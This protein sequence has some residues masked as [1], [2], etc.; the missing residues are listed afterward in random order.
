MQIE[1]DAT[2]TSLYAVDVSVP[3]A[4]IPYYPASSTHSRFPIHA[5]PIPEYVLHHLEGMRTAFVAGS[6]VIVRT[7]TAPEHALIEYWKKH[8]T[9]CPEF[10]VV[11]EGCP[12]PSDGLKHIVL[13]PH[14]SLKNEQYLIE[15]IKHYELLSKEAILKSGMPQPKSF[16]IETENCNI[17]S[18]PLPFVLKSTHGLSGDGTW[19]IKTED[20]R[21][22]IIQLIYKRKYDRIIVS[23]FV[24]DIQNNYCLQFYVSKTEEGDK[25]LGVT[26]Q[27]VDDN[28]GW[29]GSYI[30]F[31]DQ[32][33]L[34][35]KLQDIM[36]NMATFL[37]DEGYFGVV[38][39]DVLED[40]GGNLLVIDLNPRVNGSTSICL[41]RKYMTNLGRTF[42]SYLGEIKF[43]GMN[44]DQVISTL[45]EYFASGSV[46]ILG[47]ANLEDEN[48]TSC[49]IT[50]SGQDMDQLTSMER[51]IRNFT[52]RITN[53]DNAAIDTN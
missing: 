41:M 51:T 29:E 2:L 33:H 8:F 18:I 22:R 13:F 20:Q 4:L 32:D 38:G 46:V 48:T 19:L 7:K 52:H 44:P 23:D 45:E 21:D 10:M 1:L 30:N 28:G 42:M 15:P 39:I 26:C 16:V 5:P 14:P 47:M 40:S 36:H 17:R 25:F 53:D 50:V 34:Q 6:G 31:N 27:V 11:P 37:R 24:Q 9:A 3:L 12:A 43:V 49:Y 35:I